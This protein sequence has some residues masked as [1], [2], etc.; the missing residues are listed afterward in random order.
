VQNLVDQP[1]TTAK[2]LSSVIATDSTLTALLLKHANSPL[3]GFSKKIGTVALAVVVLGFDTV[4][5]IVMATSAM[6][7]ASSSFSGKNVS[8]QRFWSHSLAVASG[9]RVIAQRWRTSLPGEAFVAGLMHDLGRLVLATEWPAAYKAVLAHALEKGI[10]TYQAEK[11]VMDV[12][13]AEV[14]G[15]MGERWNLPKKILVSIREHHNVEMARTEPSVCAIYLAN[16]LAHREGFGHSKREPTPTIDE[17]ALELVAG[18]DERSVAKEMREAY[19][20]AESFL[21]IIARPQVDE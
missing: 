6:N 9:A 16:N 21:E 13:H 15:W 17:Q 1:D 4:R 3:Y 19:F 18:F 5:E 14:A 8:T 20:K 2:E 10:P 7:S 12:T 11:K